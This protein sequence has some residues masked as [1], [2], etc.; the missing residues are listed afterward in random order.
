MTAMTDR[1]TATTGVPTPEQGRCQL[2]KSHDHVQHA[3][4]WA[5]RGVETLRR[6]TNPE[7]PSDFAVADHGALLRPDLPWA[8]GMPIIAYRSERPA[9]D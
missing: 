1:C 4:V 8:P 6:W 5:L 2:V 3:L 7:L 9:D